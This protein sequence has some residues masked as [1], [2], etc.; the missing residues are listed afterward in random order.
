MLLLLAACGGDTPDVPT[1]AATEAASK[2]RPHRR[3]ADRHRRA[4]EHRRAASDG[5]AETQATTRPRRARRRRCRQPRRLCPGAGAGAGGDFY[6]FVGGFSLVPPSR[7]RSGEQ[8]RGEPRADGTGF[9]YVQITN[10][11]YELDGQAFAN[12]VTHR[13]LNFF[14]DFA[15]YELISQEI[16]Q[17]NGQATVTKYLT[18]DGVPR[19]SSPSTTSTGR[20]STATTSGP[21]RSFRRLRRPLRRGW[22]PR[23]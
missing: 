22:A 14:D 13:D 10:T 23:R 4:G 1:L 8:R 3:R 11:G 16:D 20:S 18:F 5:Y 12:F 15:D 17:S 6:P 2:R 7:W 19:P 9:I 21:T